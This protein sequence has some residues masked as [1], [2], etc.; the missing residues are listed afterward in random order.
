MSLALYPSS[1]ISGTTFQPL[2]SDSAATHSCTA[3]TFVSLMADAGLL[4]ERIGEYVGHGSSYMVDRYRHLLQ[5][6]E[7]EAARMMDDYLARADTTRRI[8]QLD[9]EG[10]T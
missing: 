7:A 6:H 1:M 10:E 9:N 5:G 8:E 4:L 3:S 2:R